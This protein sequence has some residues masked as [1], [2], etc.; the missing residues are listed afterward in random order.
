MLLLDSIPPG[1]CFRIC[2]NAH[3]VVVDG[4]FRDAQFFIMP[5]RSVAVLCSNILM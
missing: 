4:S 2:R 3:D 5:S 1:R